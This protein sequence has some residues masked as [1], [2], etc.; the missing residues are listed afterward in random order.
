[1]CVNM[2]EPSEKADEKHTL[3]QRFPQG[4]DMDAISASPSLTYLPDRACWGAKASKTGVAAR[5]RNVV[6][7]I[8]ILVIVIFDENCLGC[9]SN[10]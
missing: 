7:W 3:E 10:G 1:M 8:F 9:F 5:S 6:I 4:K 2:C